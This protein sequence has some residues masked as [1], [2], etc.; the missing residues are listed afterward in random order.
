MHI[1]VYLVRGVELYDP[2]HRGQVQSSSSHIGA[3][4][5]TVTWIWLFELFTSKQ[6]KIYIYIKVI[7]AIRVIRIGTYMFGGLR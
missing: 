7:R 2:I 5:N 4:Q 6:N 3:E 1:A